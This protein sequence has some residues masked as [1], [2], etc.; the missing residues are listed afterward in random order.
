MSLCVADARRLGSFI[1][2]G[3]VPCFCSYQS[4][5]LYVYRP[6]AVR[7][8]YFAILYTL[9]WDAGPSAYSAFI[10]PWCSPW[11]VLARKKNPIFQYD[12]LYR[13]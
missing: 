10:S 8:G 2:W 5:L 3:D 1:P 4:V 11:A 7:H 9:P 13:F 6:A 12:V